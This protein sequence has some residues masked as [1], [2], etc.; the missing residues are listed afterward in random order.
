MAKTVR[1]IMAKEKHPIQFGK[2]LWEL[3]IIAA[4]KASLKQK[5]TITPAEYVRQV[6]NRHLKRKNNA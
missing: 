2:T 1:L 4:A 6:I 3:L 5:K